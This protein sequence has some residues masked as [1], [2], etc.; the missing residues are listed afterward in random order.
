MSK[1]NQ[2]IR[3]LQARAQFNAGVD[4]GIQI[5]DAEFEQTID[6][7]LL[8]L[9]GIVSALE[10]AAQRFDQCV[11]SRGRGMK[12]ELNDLQANLYGK[13]SKLKEFWDEHIP[14]D[15]YPTFLLQKVVTP[16][17]NGYW[18][19]ANKE[20]HA[21]ERLLE[22]TKQLESAGDLI[23]TA[24]AARKKQADATSV[25]AYERIKAHLPTSKNKTEAFKSVAKET[26]L[27]CEAVKQIYQRYKGK[28]DS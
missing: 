16:R 18:S 5:R 1:E 28:R 2:L 13:W 27:S 4:K 19:L 21:Y 9:I 8:P 25:Y 3:Q 14:N 15:D 12:R 23:V 22:L 24:I 20:N 10:G 26:G 6:D 17:I 11:I 7:Y